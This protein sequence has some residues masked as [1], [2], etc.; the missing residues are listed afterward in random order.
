MFRS[1]QQKQQLNRE[2]STT[3][4]S[5]SPRAAAPT[6]AREQVCRKMGGG[7]VGGCL[8]FYQVFLPGPTRGSVGPVARGCRPEQEEQPEGLDLGCQ[9][10]QRRDGRGRGSASHPR[11][12]AVPGHPP[13]RVSRSGPQLPL[14]P[15][16]QHPCPANL[17]RRSWQRRRLSDRPAA[18]LGSKPN[19]KG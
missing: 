18:A 3:S 5:V 19:T 10:C 1:K 17:R 15:R 4:E 2:A 6:A 8:I 13:T 16:R 7:E 14:L 12:S 11:A 9:R